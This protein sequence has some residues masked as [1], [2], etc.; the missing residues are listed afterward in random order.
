MIGKIKCVLGSERVD[1]ED[2]RGEIESGVCVHKELEMRYTMR[3][4]SAHHRENNDAREYP[5]ALYKAQ[6][7]K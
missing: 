1:F 4:C 7:S 2:V 6:A 5:H 3:E